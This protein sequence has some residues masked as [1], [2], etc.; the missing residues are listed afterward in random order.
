LKRKK[1]K[2]KKKEGT[3]GPSLAGETAWMMEGEIK[4]QYG[5][6]EDGGKGRRKAHKKR[7]GMR[8]K[9]GENKGEEGGE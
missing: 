5:K 8:Q 3:Q 4:R 6:R 2:K 9:K 1:Q 7:S